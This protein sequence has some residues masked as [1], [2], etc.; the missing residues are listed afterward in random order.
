MP[1]SHPAVSPLPLY[2]A[3]AAEALE[4]GEAFISCTA[5]AE[6]LNLRPVLVRKDL[7][8]TGIAGLPRKGFPTSELLRCLEESLAWGGLNKA[9]LIGAGRLGSALLEYPHFSRYGLNLL[10]AFDIDRRKIA[11]TIGGKPVYPL[12]RLPPFARQEGVLIAVL[13]VP[14]E[15]AQCVADLAVQAGIRGLWN[16][17]PV[18]LAVPSEVIVQRVE[19]AASLAILSKRMT[20]AL[21]SQGAAPGASKAFSKLLQFNA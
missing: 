13:T 15:A 11:R 20:E 4:R 6:Q 8:S 2:R 21:H 18:K 5:I 14:A 10:A 9:C 17:T 7:E 1:I 3:L 12:E 19:L 16:F